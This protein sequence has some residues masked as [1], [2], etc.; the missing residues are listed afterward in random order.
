MKALLICPDE[1][2]EVSA[3]AGPAPLA[4]LCFLGKPFIHYWLE[5]LA[6]TGAKEIKILAVDRPDQIRK[7]IGTGARWGLRVEVIPESHE[8]TCDEARA[9]YCDLDSSDW[10]QK[11]N[12]ISFIDH[13]PGFPEQKLF[14]SYI[15]YFS[16]IQFWVSQNPN[17]LQIGAKEI[18][19]GIWIGRRTQI[20]SQAKLH[21]PCWIGENVLIKPDAEIG[22]MAILENGVVVENAATISESWIGTET[23]V[24]NL[25]QVQSSL[26]L[27]DT[28]V[29][30]RRASVAKI[31]DPFLLCALRNRNVSINSG[32]F[33]GRV[34]AVV[35]A[36]LTFPFALITILK[37]KLQGHRALRPRRAAAP[38]I[39]AESFSS[40]TYFEFSNSSS[41][42]R[43][44]PQ[45]W[46]V[47]RGEFTWIGNRPLTL[48]EAGKL[49]N[50]FERMWLV[51]P[52]G[53]ISQ[54]EAEGCTDIASDEARAHASFYAAQANWRLDFAVFFKAL[55]RLA[56][57]KLAAPSSDQAGEF[58]EQPIE[59]T[60]P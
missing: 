35:V 22:P 19:P 37:A 41:W 29:N 20:S 30:F 50:E 32:H 48:I 1:C 45:L 21:A 52:I 23:F 60:A 3:L 57:R 33:L 56:G 18:Q 5:H 8:L 16:A 55:L 2:P 12:D 59:L 24:G 54:G 49:V 34:A 31:P 53:L 42:W 38:E 17:R 51:A 15:K 44:W 39:D 6:G 36:S 40:I 13:L 27:G 10:L 28:L 14:E 11:P 9:K 7:A 25:T 47:M 4:N 46:N 58:K 26:A 43:R